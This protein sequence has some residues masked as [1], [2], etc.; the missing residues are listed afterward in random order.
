MATVN[1]VG[2]SLTGST[3]SGAFVGATG[4]ALLL[5]SANNF[6]SGFTTTATAAG[7]TVLTVNSNQIQEFTGVT[8][9]TVT[10]PVTSTLVVGQSYTILNNSSGAVTVNSSGGNAIQVLATNTSAVLT[11][12]LTSGTTAASWNVSYIVDAGG[13]VSPG[14]QNQLAWFSAT[15]NVVSGLSTANNGV[16]VTSAGGVPSISST[17]PAA[18]AATNMALTTPLINAIYDTAGQQALLIG[19]V[20]SAANSFQIN[21]NT[22]GSAPTL[23]SVGSDAAISMALN[24]KSTGVFRLLTE[25]TTNQILLFSQAGYANTATLNFPASSNTY[26][27][28]ATTGTVGIYNTGTWTPTLV[29][30]GG[31][32][33]TYTLQ[34]AAYTQIGNRIMFNINLVL[35]GLGTLAAGTLTI[36]GLPT[37]AAATVS[38]ATAFQSLAVGATTA[39]AATT[40]NA[41]TVIT[42]YKFAAGSLTQLADTDLQAT[43]QFIISG[44]YII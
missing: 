22:A 37:A 26:T 35:S 34:Q 16:L 43:S 29:S 4:P 14:T 20:G 28:P 8:T 13:G 11:C 17:L 7:T 12:I 1:A 36:A 5:P 15:G 41:S 44:T 2:N 31:G 10:M 42:L 19:T 21:N 25:A 23:L 38:L 39:T 24:T 18:I 3:G 32:A 6:L 40:A 30:S 9:Q 33:P 27:F